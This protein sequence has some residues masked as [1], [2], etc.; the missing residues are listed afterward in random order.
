MHAIR[1]PPD[2]RASL[3]QAAAAQVEGLARQRSPEEALDF[4]KQ[5]IRRVEPAAMVLYEM[6]LLQYQLGESN[7]ALKYYDQAIALD[8]NLATARYDRAEIR[9]AQGDLNGAREDLQRAA[10][11]RSDHWVIHFRL[12]EIAGHERD[13]AAMDR[14]LFQ[15]LRH[16]FDFRTIVED[17]TWR[18][19]SRDPLLGPII[20][21]FIIVYSDEQILQKLREETP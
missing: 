7:A 18:T 2:Y 16:G 6:G 17:P 3:H 8:P 9:L 11:V 4:G 15:A 5:F 10:D 13:A 12:A 21:R 20:A 19:W 14:H 1:D